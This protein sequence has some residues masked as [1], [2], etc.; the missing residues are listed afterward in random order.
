MDDDAAFEARFQALRDHVE[1][2]VEDEETTMF[3]QAAQVLAT[4][5]EAMTLLLQERKAQILAS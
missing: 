5:L 2:H 1:Q 4:H 3:P